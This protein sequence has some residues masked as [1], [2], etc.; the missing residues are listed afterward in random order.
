[1]RQQSFFFTALLTG[2][3][4]L[5]ACETTDVAP[6]QSG[7]RPDASTDE[8]GLWLQ[9]DEAEK[10][11]RRSAVLERDPE[12]NA[13]VRDIV[14]RVA[15]DDFCNDVRVYIVKQPFFNANMAPNGVMQ[16]WTGLMLRSENEAQLAFVIG[17]EIA[18]Y[19]QRH[20]LKQWRELK[21]A[22]NAS[23]VFGIGLAAAGV[24]EAATL[25][26]F[27]LAARI[28]G[29]GR[30]KEREADDLGYAYA[31]DAGYDGREAAAI[32]EYL[33]SEVEASDSKRK[34]RRIARSSIF[35]THPV[36]TERITT[37]AEKAGEVATGETYEE[38]Y[39]EMTAPF[40]AKWLDADLVRRDYGENIFLINHLIERGEQLGILYY[41][42]AEAY[43]I[44]RGDGDA[45]LALAD[46]QKAITYPDAPADAWREIGEAQRKAGDM[47]AAA[48]NFRTYLDKAPNAKDRALIESYIAQA[49]V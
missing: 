1:M 3:L 4:M 11:L 39:V 19:R 37:L 24:P 44:R 32:W 35:S 14:C 17:H 31:V 49:G 2:F 10:A 16:V 36:T 48:R 21:N 12:L 40:L 45:A 23:L 26:D 41:R 33:V 28:Y 46:Y 29:F 20:S 15:T 7:E 43:R 25:G 27:A 18:H 8:A 22:A 42:R 34:K 30:D 47:A 13:Y 5:A 6:I 9:M 38:R